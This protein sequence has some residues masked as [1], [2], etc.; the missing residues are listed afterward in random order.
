[1]A[2][3]IGSCHFVSHAAACRYYRDYGFTAV[4]VDRKLAEGEIA[5]GRPATMPG[6]IVHV[7]DLGTRYAIERP[8]NPAVVAE[9][10]EAIRR[11]RAGEPPAEKDS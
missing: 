9:V 2:Q 5:L 3:F 8:T 6:D 11:H 1:M 4:D 7:I 10:R